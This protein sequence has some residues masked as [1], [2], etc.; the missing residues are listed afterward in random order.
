MTL[1]DDAV[2]LNLDL[3]SG[4]HEVGSVFAVSVAGGG[5]LGVVDLAKGMSVNRFKD[6][7]TNETDRSACL[8]EVNSGRVELR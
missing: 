8:G 4:R 2:L 1:E 3:A 6:F 5:E 7:V